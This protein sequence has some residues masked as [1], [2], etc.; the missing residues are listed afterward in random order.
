LRPGRKAHVEFLKKN[1][2]PYIPEIPLSMEY[3]RVKKIVNIRMDA[4]T[5]WL[6]LQSRLQRGKNQKGKFY[7]HHVHRQ[8]T[9]STPEGIEQPHYQSLYS[10]AEYS[11]KVESGSVPP[12]TMYTG[13]ILKVH[14]VRQNDRK[15]R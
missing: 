9:Q 1:N 10:M 14:S 7:L 11:K 15:N 5:R 8:N 12:N 6:C 4:A 3:I 13:R 2:S